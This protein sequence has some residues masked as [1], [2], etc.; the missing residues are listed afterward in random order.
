MSYGQLLP[1]KKTPSSLSNPFLYTLHSHLSIYLHL[2]ISRI[3][4]YKDLKYNLF[5]PRYLPKLVV[6]DYVNSC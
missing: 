3:T 2:S 1:Y 6:S 5:T 4:S